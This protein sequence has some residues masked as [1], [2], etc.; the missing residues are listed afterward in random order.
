MVDEAKR[1]RD[2]CMN[3]LRSITSVRNANNQLDP[4]V[5]VWAREA[6]P[7]ERVYM[8]VGDLFEAAEVLDLEEE[9]IARGASMDRDDGSE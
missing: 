4:P 5:A 1:Y 6:P 3:S 9:R 8:A 2:P 7:G